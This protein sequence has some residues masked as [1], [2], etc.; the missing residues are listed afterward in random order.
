MIAEDLTALEALGIAIRAETDAS[1]VYSELAGR[2][3]NPLLRQKIELLAKEESQHRRIL[4]LAYQERFPDVPLELP[5]SQLP[6]QFSCKTL[7]ERL[8]LKDVISCAIEEERRSHEFYLRAAARSTDLSGPMM[9]RFLADWE[10]SHQ[11][12]LMAEYEMVV[13][14]P[15]HLGQDIEPWK[16]A[17]R[18]K[19][20]ETPGMEI[21]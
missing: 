6:A 15:R 19:H 4:E 21:Y 18:V 5:R 14:Y 9:F 10:F 1:E 7:R 13:R 11:M 17:A 8:S 2:L 16:P 3:G 12:A 20:F